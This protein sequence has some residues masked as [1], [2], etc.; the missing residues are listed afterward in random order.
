VRGPGVRNLDFS[1]FK[2]FHIRERA[3][4]QFRA[5]CFNFTNTPAFG[6]PD[7]VYSSQTFGRISSAGL[8]RQTQFAL[9]LLF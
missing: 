7:Q 8:P 4:L 5:E 6:L 3:N 9:K 1:G 2:N